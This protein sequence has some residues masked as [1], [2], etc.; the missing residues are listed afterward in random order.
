M[1]S[2]S[3]FKLKMP[4][5]TKNEY[6]WAITFLR[7]LLFSWSHFMADISEFTVI[8]VDRI[9]REYSTDIFQNNQFLIKIFPSVQILWNSLQG[10]HRIDKE[11]K[12]WYTSACSS[13]HSFCNELSCFMSFIKNFDLPL[14]LRFRKIWMGNFRSISLRFWI[15]V[16][17]YI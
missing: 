5:G 3:R 15:A 11:E 9:C 14:S 4:Q 7:L 13:Q 16:I 1:V 10:E 8:T 6:E 12:K 17:T 2:V